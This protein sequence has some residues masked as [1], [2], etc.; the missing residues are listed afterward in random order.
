AQTAPNSGC[1]TWQDL[2]GTVLDFPTAI[3]DGGRV[4]LF[5]RNGGGGVSTTAQTAPNSGCDTWQDL[6]G[7]VLDF[8]TAIVDGGG[9]L[10]VFAVGTD[11][12]VRFRTGTTATAFGDWQVLPL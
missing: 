4:V 5:E 6:G 12:R 10:H 3:V 8:P 2:G 9:V 11:G 7:T 1:D